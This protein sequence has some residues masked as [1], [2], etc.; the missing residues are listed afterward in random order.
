MEKIMIVTAWNNG[1]HHQSGAGYGL[2]LSIV[3]RDLYFNRGWGNALIRLQGES[4]NISVNIN[5]M[6]FWDIRCRELISKDIGKW[7]IKNK[8]TPWAKG[9]P[10]KMAME[11][12]TQNIFEVTF[13]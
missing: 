6:S 5:K 1:K 12:L 3:D 8:K 2:K 11:H 4:S 9:H 10:P 7:L 13:K